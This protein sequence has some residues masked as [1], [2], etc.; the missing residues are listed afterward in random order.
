VYGKHSSQLAFLCSKDTGEWGIHDQ[1]TF[2]K[3]L[4]RVEQ[5]ELKNDNNKRTKKV[6]YND[7]KDKLI[8]YIELR[9][10]FYKHDKCQLSWAVLKNKAL[11]FAKI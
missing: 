7:V 2:N 8:E 4:K 6:P 11:C 10:R 5:G 3:V 9:E 1:R